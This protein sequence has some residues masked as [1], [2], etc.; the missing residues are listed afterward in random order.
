MSVRPILR[1]WFICFLSL[2]IGFPSVSLLPPCDVFV[3]QTESFVLS[4]H[5]LDL[6]DGILV[7]SFKLFLYSWPFLS[8]GSYICKLAVLELE[9]CLD[10]DSI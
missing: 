10:S 6:V 2:L 7:M 1:N 3:K 5:R 4:S 9:V 8:I